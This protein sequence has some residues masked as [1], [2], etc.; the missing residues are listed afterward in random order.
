MPSK[1]YNGNTPLGSLRLGSLSD[2]ELEVAKRTPK[3]AMTT[4]VVQ[5]HNGTFHT[6]KRRQ[7]A[8]TT[9][10]GCIPWKPR[11]VDERVEGAEDPD[12]KLYLNAGT[13]NGVISATWNASVDFPTPPAEGDPPVKF[14]VLKLLLNESGSFLMSWKYP[15]KVLVRSI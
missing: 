12:Y 9:S 13:V 5:T 1:K 7:R 4:G 3:Q 6:P 14:I 2:V 8:T 15:V 10:S 11:I